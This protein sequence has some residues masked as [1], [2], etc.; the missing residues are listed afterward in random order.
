MSLVKSRSLTLVCARCF[1]IRLR[2]DGCQSNAGVCPTSHPRSV[3]R[4][5][6]LSSKIIYLQSSWPM[7]RPIHM[8]L[9]PWTFGAWESFYLHFCAEVCLS[10]YVSI[11][12]FTMKQTRRGTNLQ[13]R[14]VLNLRGFLQAKSYLNLLGI[15]YQ[16][17]HSV[18]RSICCE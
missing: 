4:S 11:P 7:H 15:V 2:Y 9:N 17:P 16:T 3:E 18:R 1:G 5:Q 14:T 6:K 12:L 13:Q 8:K 10:R